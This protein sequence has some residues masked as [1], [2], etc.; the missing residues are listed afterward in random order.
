VLDWLEDKQ[1]I[2][3]ADFNLEQMARMKEQCK[4]NL[5]AEEEGAS[6]G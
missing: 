6:V 2:Q 1:W 5:R 4:Q 3:H